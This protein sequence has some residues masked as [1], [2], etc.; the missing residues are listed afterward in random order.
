MDEVWNESGGS[1]EEED[2]FFDEEDPTSPRKRRK[3]DSQDG[4][5]SPRSRRQAREERLDREEEYYSATSF[6]AAASVLLWQLASDLGKTDNQLLWMSIVGL[7]DQFLHERIDRC[8]AP[9]RSLLRH[10]RTLLPRHAARNRTKISHA[11]G[12]GCQRHVHRGCRPIVRRCA[13][14]ERD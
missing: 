2:E 14:D 1:D 13:E 11:S 10:W 3:T 9:S 12:R 6:G 5:L 7:T 4:R 8:D